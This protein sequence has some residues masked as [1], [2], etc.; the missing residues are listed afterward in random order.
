MGHGAPLR[1]GRAKAASAASYPYYD[2]AFKMWKYD[3]QARISG[4]QRAFHIPIWTG[5]PEAKR[6]EDAKKLLREFASQ[7]NNAVQNF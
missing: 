3:F 1:P 7:L 2:P 4:T 6:D 5:A